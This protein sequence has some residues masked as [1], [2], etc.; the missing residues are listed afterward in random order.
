V[1]LTLVNAHLCILVLKTLPKCIGVGMEH[2]EKTLTNAG[3]PQVLTSN[4]LVIKLRC[5]QMACVPQIQ[6]PA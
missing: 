2:V 1:F 6:I 3:H 5:A 4:A